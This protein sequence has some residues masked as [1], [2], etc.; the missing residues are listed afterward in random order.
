MA[1]LGVPASGV[2]LRLW[3]LGESPPLRRGSKPNTGRMMGHHWHRMRMPCSRLT[4]PVH[5]GKLALNPELQ[6][7]IPFHIDCRTV[8]GTAVA[9]RKHSPD[10]QCSHASYDMLYTRVESFL[11]TEDGSCYCEV[12]EDSKHFKVRSGTAS[13]HPQIQCG[14]RGHTW[15][16]LRSGQYLGRL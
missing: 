5:V 11:Y 9:T 1:L 3:K 2:M 6:A 13:I 4:G 8:P 7:P 10:R 12:V 15:V 16:A 14:D